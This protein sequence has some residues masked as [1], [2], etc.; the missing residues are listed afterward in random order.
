[1]LSIV[2][3]L[4]NIGYLIC[5][6]INSAP[7]KLTE[8]KISFLGSAMLQVLA[9]AQKARESHNEEQISLCERMVEYKKLV[10]QESKLSLNGPYGSP[11]GEG[12]HVQPFSRISNKVVDAVTES[13][14]DGK[15]FQYMMFISLREFSFNSFHSP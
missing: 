12:V 3:F 8:R 9:Y 11:S 2:Y 5:K 6:N 7:N 4:I 14:A 13:A 10:H 15:V 1:M